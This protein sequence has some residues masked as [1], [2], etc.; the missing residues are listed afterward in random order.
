MTDSLILFFIPSAL[1]VFRD[2]SVELLYSRR[3]LA[4]FAKIGMAP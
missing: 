3:F 4:D 2:L 1:R